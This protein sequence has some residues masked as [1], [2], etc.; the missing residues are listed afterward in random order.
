M[1]KHISRRIENVDAEFRI[2]DTDVNV[3]SED[4][5]TVRE[6]LQLF[7]YAEVALERIDVLLLPR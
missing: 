5:E 4:Q 7:L 3:C 6:I 2:F 1:G